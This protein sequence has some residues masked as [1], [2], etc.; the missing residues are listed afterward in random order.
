[1]DWALAEAT[2]RSMKRLTGSSGGKGTVLASDSLAATLS[3]FGYGS[4][5]SAPP[6]RL[7]KAFDRASG[8]SRRN[9][10]M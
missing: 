8:T 3:R 5:G 1:M 9:Q 2:I 4:T 10:Q 7:P 6:N